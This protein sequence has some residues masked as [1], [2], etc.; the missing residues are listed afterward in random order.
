M[1]QSKVQVLVQTHSKMCRSDMDWSEPISTLPARVVKLTESLNQQRY[2]DAQVLA[3]EIA[4]SMSEVTLWIA[5]EN[6]NVKRK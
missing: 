3:T 2:L 4:I 1:L 5:R 6:L